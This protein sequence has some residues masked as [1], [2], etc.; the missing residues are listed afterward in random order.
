SA[1]GRRAH[2]GRL[3][4]GRAGAAFLFRPRRPG[5]VAAALHEFQGLAAHVLAPD[6]GGA[7]EGLPL[8]RGLQQADD[9]LKSP[10]AGRVGPRERTTGGG[11]KL[12]GEHGGVLTRD[13]SS[14]RRLGPR[15][16]APRA[17]GC[18]ASEPANVPEGRAGGPA[19]RR[20]PPAGETPERWS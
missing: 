2:G 7:G 6:Q 20:G 11:A 3:T 19:V 8:P 4:P 15:G 12:A 14:P 1:G 10:R 18:R 13:G 5:E 9:R 16:P 17:G